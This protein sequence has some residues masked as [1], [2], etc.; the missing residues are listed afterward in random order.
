MWSNLDATGWLERIAQGGSVESGMRAC[1]DKIEQTDKHINAFHHVFAG[2]A[3]EQARVCDAT[4]AE[5][6][7]PLHGLPIAIKEENAIAG[8]PTAFG[9]A[10][11]S[12]PATEDSAVVAA[13]RRAG[14][15]IVGTTRMPEFGTWP[16]TESQNGGVTRNPLD[17][18]FS[19]GGSSGGS[20]AAVAAGMVPVA[21]GGD[22]GGSIR[23]PAAHC[24]LYGLKPC[25]GRVSTAPAEHLWWDLGTIGPLAK[26]PR[27]LRLIYSVIGQ[28]PAVPLPK[29]L[30]IAVHVNPKIAGVMVPAQL[31][32]A[33]LQAAEQ[34]AKGENG[35]IVDTDLRLP[36][37]TDAFM[38][39][40]LGGLVAEVKQLDQPEKIEKRSRQLVRTGRA[41]VA[42]DMRA[43]SISC[44]IGMT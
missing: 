27:D 2:N 42:S 6:R 7:G 11:M 1:L 19:P 12:T 18:R 40:F 14:A 15:I 26:S 17:L 22:G 31:T 4:P 13:L 38:P 10:A 36:T 28:F 30:R 21:V 41:N 5:K 16:F 39:Q 43:T 23:I 3:L 37:P 24:G 34:L 44:W 9:T 20:A 8:I 29:Q 32:D 35:V 33:A 25:R